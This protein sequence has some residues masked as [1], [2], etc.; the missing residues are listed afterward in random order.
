MSEAP[1]RIQLSRKRG[2][3]LQEASRAIN[4]LPAV[5]VDRT[6]VWGNPFKV[7]APSSSALMA[8]KHFRIWLTVA[9]SEPDPNREFILSNIS[10]LRGHN[11]ACWCGPDDCCHASVLLALANGAP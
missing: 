9:T 10:S 8:V 5:K 2:W 6:T 7:D 11:L 4:G 1:V 3:C